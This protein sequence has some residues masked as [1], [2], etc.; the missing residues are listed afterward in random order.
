MLQ[1]FVE[2]KGERKE[3]KFLC[4]GDQVKTK[5]TNNIITPTTTS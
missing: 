2:K 1:T 3:S 5:I 4:L